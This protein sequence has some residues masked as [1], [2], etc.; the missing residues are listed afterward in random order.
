MTCLAIKR[1][2]NCGECIRL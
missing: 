2:G 1:D